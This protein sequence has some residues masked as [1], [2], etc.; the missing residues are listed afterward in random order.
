MAERSDEDRRLAKIL[1]Y[2][3]TLAWA[4]S[5]AIDTVNP[6]YDP[7]AYIGPLML[8]VAGGAFGEGIIRSVVKQAINTNGNGNGKKDP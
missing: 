8:L 2:T 4:I 5:F 6:K 7:P 3:I 1:A